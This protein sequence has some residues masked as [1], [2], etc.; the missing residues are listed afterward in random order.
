M[1][2]RLFDVHSQ[3]LNACP[4]LI[5]PHFKDIVSFVVKAY[6]ETFC[7]S[8]LNYV[9][10]AVESFDS[11]QIVVAA[12]L[13][14]QGKSALFTQLL[15]HIYQCTFQCTSNTIQTKD[16][17]D[18]VIKAFFELAQRYLLF[19]P[20]ALC[21]WPE[22]PSLF[23]LGSTRLACK[24]D[25]DST[26]SAVVF[27]TQFIGWK[28]IHMPATKVRVLRNYSATIDNLLLQHGE[29]ITKSC[30]G[31][32]SGGAPQILWPS[33]S[34]CLF[35]VM[36]HII[37]ESTSG[38]P[39]PVLQSWLRSAM[40]DNSLLHNSQNITPEIGTTMIQILC[41]LAKQGVK[42]KPKAK[43]VM[44]DFGKITKGETSPE[45]LQAYQ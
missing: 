7:A 10:A 45:A 41:D 9:S 16:P 28:S 39:N 37:S 34:E 30:I 29:T 19:C 35:A 42:S 22:L 15:S 32:I 13:D 1:L 31:G 11:E 44:T 5:A 12:G 36:L 26:R 43:M 24:G 3:L 25:I 21:Q 38:E 33:L 2:S 6:E 18:L 40:T 20:D 8:A 27:L 4:T 23:A 17:S 14:D